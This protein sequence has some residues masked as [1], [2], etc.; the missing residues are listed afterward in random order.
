MIA[1]RFAA[2]FYISE[3]FKGVLVVVSVEGDAVAVMRVDA[4]PGAPYK[5]D[6]EEVLHQFRYIV[7]VA[8]LPAI[9]EPVLSIG[10]HTK[11]ITIMA[12]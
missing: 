11:N 2:L 7:A 4:A 5:P 6:A 1:A 9:G 12:V 10:F 8:F 3:Q